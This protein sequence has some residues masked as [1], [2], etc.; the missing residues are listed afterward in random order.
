MGLF[1]CQR[2]MCHAA[3]M[4]IPSMN[5]STSNVDP[6]ELAKFSDLAHRWWDL[7]SEFNTM[8]AGSKTEVIRKELQGIR[9][10]IN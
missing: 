5:Q 6:A 9:W 2:L 7:D 8:R 4:T 3:C 1:L 10:R